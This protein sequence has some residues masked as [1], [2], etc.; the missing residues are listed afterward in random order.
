LLAV[1][2]GGAL[3]Y[4]TAGA[5]GGIT[6]AVAVALGIGAVAGLAWAIDATVG[7]PSRTRSF[8]I[9]AAGLVIA[10]WTVVPTTILG[11]ILPIWA[12]VGG[13]ALV[14]VLLGV[15]CESPVG[16]LWHG[17][18]AGGAGGVLTV[19]LAIYESFTM[20][21]ELDGIVLIAGLFAPLAFS[22]AGGL[23]G[24]VGVSTLDAVG[25]ARV[26]E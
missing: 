26:S 14:G 1:L 3:G 25:K 21:P 11:P 15:T 12:Y 19:Y 13:I 20:Q 10:G 24:A 22:V 23:G 6:A 16:G 7:R 18:L 8:S 5:D 2:A 17:L 9:L 4:A